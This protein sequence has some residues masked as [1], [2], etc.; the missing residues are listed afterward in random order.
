MDG[1]ASI[2]LLAEHTIWR[3]YESSFVQ[4][5]TL[6]GGWYGEEGFR[7]GPVGTATY[8]QRWRVDPWAELVYGA[9]ISERMYDGEGARVIGAFITLR[10]KI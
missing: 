4:A 3:R 5:L 1:S 6:E 10:R 7:G 2:S 8:E 9:F